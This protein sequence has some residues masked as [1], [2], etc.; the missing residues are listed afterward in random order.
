MPHIHKHIDFVTSAFIVRRA[1]VL[2]IF[3]KKY[4]EWLPIGGHI[5]LDEDP[6]QALYREIK[7]E[8]GLKVTILSKSPRIHHPGV[9]PLPNPDYMDIHH[10]GGKH[11][12]I[13]LVYFGTSKSDRVKLHT[14]EHRE[15]RWFQRSELK[16]PRYK[17][18]R[19]IRFYCEKA[20]EACEK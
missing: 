8:C 19:S 17:I 9:K 10:I 11:R 6:E 2:L 13:A 4:R 3:H 20:L 16:D 7:E 12:H 18:I 5:E 14:R 1:R 15:F